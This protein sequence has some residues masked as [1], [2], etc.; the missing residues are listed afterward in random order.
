[1]PALYLVPSQLLVYFQ[2]RE[3]LEGSIG[4]VVK[5]DDDTVQVRFDLGGT[6]ATYSCA[7]IA[8]CRI[9]WGIEPRL[10]TAV[11]DEY[12]WTT[13]FNDLGREFS[14]QLRGEAAHL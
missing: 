9:P 2:L 11:D 3:L 8:L 5:V 4:V 10:W 7:P 12:V 13:L 6:W 1:M 14:R